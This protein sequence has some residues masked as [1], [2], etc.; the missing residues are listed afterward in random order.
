MKK[1]FIAIF[2]LLGLGMLCWAQG[3]KDLFDAKKSEAELEIMKG[4]LGTT[5]SYAAQNQ[6]KDIWYMN[7]TNVSAYYLVGQGAV[8]VIPTSTFRG[9]NVKLN[10]D[11]RMLKQE[12]RQAA[13]EARKQA[14]ELRKQAAELSKSATESGIGAGVGP[15]IGNGKD[16]GLETSPEPPAPPALPA[17]PAPPAPPV[18]PQASREDLQNAVEEIQN[19]LKRSRAEAEASQEKILESLKE[20]RSNLIEA[21]ANYGDSLTQVKAGE[22]INLIISTEI[23]DTESGR[24]KARHDIISAQK[25]WITDYKAGRISLDNFKQKV[26]QYSE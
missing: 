20:I 9:Q 22:Y 24:M 5:I 7:M 1:Y 25:S 14:A 8:F 10:L 19:A 12:T 3:S 18:P 26:L 4:I 15:G 6:Q 13:L 23:V 11:L 17:P 21:M 2:V 16:P